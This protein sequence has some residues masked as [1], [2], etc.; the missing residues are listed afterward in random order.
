MATVKEMMDALR[1][2]F[3]ANEVEWRVQKS[4]ISSGN[5]PWAMVLCYVTNRAIQNRL[6]EVF[7][8]ANWR[9]EYVRWG[10]NSALCGISARIDGEWITKW[11]GAGDT[12]IEA[13]KGG[14]S[15]SMK[16][17]AVQWGIGRYLYNLT[18][19]FAQCSLEQQRGDEWRTATTP[20]KRT[21]Y[22]KIPTLPAW[23]LPAVSTT[24][25]PI[26]AKPEPPKPAAPP[27]PATPQ[28][29]ATI[30][31]N[32]MGSLGV[33]R[34]EIEQTIGKPVEQFDEANTKL[35]RSAAALMNSKNLAFQAAIQEITR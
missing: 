7:G 30:L 29:R 22:W 6:D 16:R 4:G 11:D 15:D 33:T 25:P 19:N 12:N 20:D 23:A 1:K 32:Y 3:A 8:M 27:K 10:E 13:T 5:R 2:P 28:D 34:E 35:I 26:P 9:N 31:L 14:L 21:I 17:A 24:T 18:E